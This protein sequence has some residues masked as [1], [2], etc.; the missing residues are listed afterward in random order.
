MELKMKNFFIIILISSLFLTALFAQDDSPRKVIKIDL[1]KHKKETLTKLYKLGLDV[2]LADKKNNSINVLVNKSEIQNIK[3]I[4]FETTTLLEDAD[5]F[6]CELRQ[7]GY[8]EHFHTFDQMFQEMTEIV[9]SHP[10]IVKLEDIGDSYEKTIGKGGYDIWAMKISDNVNE[11]ENEPEVFFM[12]NMHAREIITPEVILYFMHYLIDNYGTDGYVTHLVNNRQIWLC[13]TFNPDGHEYVFSGESCQN[14]NDPMLWRK[15]KRDNNNNGQFDSYGD[16]VDLNRNFGYL[17]GLDDIGS[18]PNPSSETYRGTSA[19]SEPESQAIRD[20][21]INHNFIFTL[22]FHSY[23]QLWLYPWG[24]EHAFTPDHDIFV[25]LADS[26]VFYNHYAPEI[27]ADLYPVNG[28]TDDWFYGEQTV[29][30][31]IFAFTPEVGSSS[32]AVGGCWGFYPD[33]SRIEKQILENQAPMLY[34]TYAAGEEPIVEHT[35]LTDQ[36][37]QGSYQVVAEILSP[38]VLT[39]AAAIDESTIKLYYSTDSSGP[40]ESVQ[41]AVTGNPNEF[42]GEIPDLRISGNIYYYLSASD[43]NG[44]TGSSPRGAPIATHVF[45][46]GDDTEAPVISHNPVTQGSTSSTAF[47]IQSQVTDNL[48]INS[49]KLFYRK[50][51]NPLD[52]LDMTSLSAIQ[53]EYAGVIPVD[54]VVAGDYYEYKI[55]ARDISVNLNTAQSPETGFYRIAIKNSILYDFELESTFNNDS[56]NDW[57]WGT[58]TFGPGSAHSGTKVW[59]TNLSG[60]YRDLTESILETPEISLSNKDSSKLTFWHWYSNEYSQDKYWDGGNVKISVD[61]N[62]YQLIEPADGYEGTIDDYN[63]FLGNEPGFGGPIGTGD[64]WHQEIFDLSAYTN[65]SVK[66]RFHFGSDAYSNDLGWYID[67]VEI[68]FKDLTAINLDD[69]LTVVTPERF[70]LSQN[71][72]NPFNPATEIKY[73]IAEAGKV[74][75]DIFNTLGQRVRTLVDEHQVA[76]SYTV[77]WQGNDDARRD[78]TSGIYFYQLTISGSDFNKVLMKKMVK[79]Q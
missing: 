38:I 14:Y 74:E 37:N 47:I 22:S 20:F 26:C 67:D 41:L 3:E 79:L 7:S 2:T 49:V 64:F 46:V 23:S 15:N 30:N 51:E 29:K 40:F 62:P 31:K 56:G 58:P 65:Q 72:P 61:G 19:F 54:T 45:Q 52:S 34:L 55:V 24:Y 77:F 9:A 6:A 32:E 60:N 44:V 43:Q 66:F 57:Q 33:T 10:E 8:L 4:G 27:G 53:N 78:V 18:S 70:Q 35:P 73:S 16:G 71:Y 69:Q 5:A 50:N 63:T 11:E 28:D 42:Y 59:A 1:A 76:G 13:P 25:A 36:E 48:G 21:V 68:L 17:W 12:A 75:L 39:T